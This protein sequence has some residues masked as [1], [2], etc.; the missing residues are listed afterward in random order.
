MTLMCGYYGG[1]FFRTYLAP[2][3]LLIQAPI[4]ITA[5]WIITT[6]YDGSVANF[7]ERF[8]FNEVY[9]LWPRP[10]ILAA[11]IIAAFVVFEFILLKL[12]PGE[13]YKGSPSPS[14][15]QPVY[16]LNG[17]LAYTIT[18]VAL[19]LAVFQYK[20]ISPAIAYDNLGPIIATINISA[21][22]LCTY[23]YIKG[24]WFPEHPQDIRLYGFLCDFYGGLEL[25]PTVFGVSFKQLVNCRVGMMGWSV[26][27]CFYAAKQLEATG[28][29]ANSM[30]VSNAIQLV[31]IIK[32][33]YWEGGYFR[34]I[35]I[36]HDKFGYM[37][38]WGCLCWITSVYTLVSF[39]LVTHPIEWSTERAVLM[40]AV[41]MLAIWINYDADAQRQRT[42]DTNGNTTVWGRKPKTILASYKNTKGETH[43][44]L[45]LVDGWWG[46]ARHFQYVP[47][48]TLAFMWTVPAGF[49][50]ILPYLYFVFL[51]IL[52]LDRAGRD[53]VK[54]REKYGSY[55]RKYCEAVPYRMIP[56]L[57]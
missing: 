32:F 39:W 19:Y 38:C 45:L 33:F 42:R 11:K 55:W 16:K 50:H 18:H 56:Y 43:Q 5:V 4:T 46:V 10:S 12:L 37:I 17:M 31:Y 23:L 6:Y 8:N 14:G 20:L 2:L 41:G 25:Y 52:L 51:T 48:L 34:S 13:L 53:E 24:R 36:M 9:D 29:I 27:I 35:D 26:L 28:S 49:T 21:F 47:E 40:L 1:Y 30:L 22:V 57:F 54:C 15:Y 3:F 7:V 44:N